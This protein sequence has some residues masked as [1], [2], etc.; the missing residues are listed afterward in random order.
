MERDFSRDVKVGIFVFLTL[1]LTAA[2]VFMV[3][4]SSDLFEERYTLFAGFNDVGGMKEGS[5][6]RVAGVDV[7]EVTKIVFHDVD[8]KLAHA[9]AP[10]IDGAPRL[11]DPALRNKAIHVTLSIMTRY[12]SRIRENTTAR[13]ETEGMLGDKYVSLT[14]GLPV[15]TMRDE[16]GEVSE[17]ANAPLTDGQWLQVQ[18]MVQ[19]VEYQKQANEVLA[20]IQDISRKL[21]LA[22]G[23]DQEATKASLAS[24]VSS[25]DALLLEAKE[26]DGLIHAL[27]YD[28]ALSRQLSRTVGNLEATSTELAQVTTEIR[29]GEGLAHELIYGDQGE[30]LATQLG[31]LAVALD[32]L[33]SD[34]KSEDSLIHA[35][36]YEPERASMVEDLH[37]TASSLRTIA[38]SIE[39]GEGTAGLLANDP[40][41]YEDLRALVSG[42]Q[43]NKLL[44]AYIR[45]TVSEAEAEQSEAWD[46]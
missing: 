2:T 5:V 22:M 6:V 26:G 10:I 20:D 32:A 31:E 30:Q 12:A 18:E 33:V 16:T 41:L 36:V 3:G 4:G 29:T 15:S 45:K 44:R 35:L 38:A 28:K 40:A 21:N 46:Q 24:V 37:A 43:R 7:G 13:I 25:I 39:N 8:P 34:I 14:M 17:V 1:L 27:V 11:T 19:L 23:D 9:P 42:A